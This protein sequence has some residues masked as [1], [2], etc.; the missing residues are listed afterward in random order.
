MANPSVSVE[1]YNELYMINNTLNPNTPKDT[2]PIPITAPPEKATSRA[3]FKEVLAALVV[4]TLALVAIRI[5][6]KPA[7]ADKKAPTTKDKATR[8]LEFSS[9]FPLKIKRTATANTKIDNTLYSA[10]KKAMAPS[11]I[12]LAIV[13]IFS[14]PTSCLLTQP[15]LNIINKKPSTLARGNK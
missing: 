3:L 13:A 2:T 15:D 9:E 11:A 6:I 8:P 10:F 4:L 14:D 1:L 7:K 12:F 5:P